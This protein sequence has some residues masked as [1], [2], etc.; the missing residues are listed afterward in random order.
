MNKNIDP[1]E[2]NHLWQHDVSKCLH[3]R[4]LTFLLVSLFVLLQKKN[5]KEIFISGEG[6]PK[7][8][9]SVDEDLKDL[10]HPQS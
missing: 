7:R 6:N 9:T 10:S 8:T 5:W 1:A 2:A 3:I 4:S